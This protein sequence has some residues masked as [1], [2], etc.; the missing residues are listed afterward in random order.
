MQDDDN[1]IKAALAGCQLSGPLFQ[2]LKWRRPRPSTVLRSTWY[3][4]RPSR[5]PAPERAPPRTNERAS[6]T[7]DRKEKKKNSVPVSERSLQD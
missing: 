3:T 4:T 6:V 1:V 2:G 7:R 5:L